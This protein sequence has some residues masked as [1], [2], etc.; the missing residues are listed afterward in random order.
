MD[1]HEKHIFFFFS[2]VEN[3]TTVSYAFG[4]G[5]SSLFVNKKK[6]QKT[7]KRSIYGGKQKKAKSIKKLP[8]FSSLQWKKI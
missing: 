4:F 1:V 6:K 2:I 3:L 5:F 8:P 7:N